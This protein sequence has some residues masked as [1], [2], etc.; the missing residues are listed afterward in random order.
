[1]RI[2]SRCSARAVWKPLEWGRDP[3][4]RVD[5]DGAARHGRVPV[6][7]QVGPGPVQHHRRLERG[8]RDLGRERADAGGGDAG[9]VRHR[10]GR[11]VRAEILPG[12]VLQDAAVGDAARLV[13]RGEIGLHPLAVPGRGRAGAA[14]DD[15]RPAVVVLQERA[16]ARRGGVGVDEAGRVGEAGEVVRVD[17]PRLEQAVHEAE[18]QEPVGAGRDAEPVVGHRVVAGADRV[19]RDDLR[20]PRL[21]LADADLERVAV[22]VL[23]HPE[24]EE[25]LR[26]LPVGRAELPEGAA[27][28]GDPGGGH[29]D[30]A[31]AAMRGVVGRAKRLRPPRGEGLRLVAPGEEGEAARLGRAD[32]GEPF[33]RQ[34]QRLVPCDLAEPARPARPVAQQ[35]RAEA[36]GRGRLHDPGR[37][38]G[39]KHA[40][41]H[42]MVA[43]ALDIGE[44]AVLEVDVD[45][46]AAGAHV[47]GGLAHLVRDARRRVEAVVCARHVWP[48]PPAPLAAAVRPGRIP[49][50]E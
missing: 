50:R 18:D 1:M 37:A 7:A 13:R 44:A 27:D 41:V 47:A 49:W 4:H 39:A 16:A 45:A 9:A 14:V 23:G 15:Q 40:P 24:E 30:R 36:G 48:V 20:A 12:D 8:A 2:C 28:G 10:L 43:V 31:E 3:A 25:Q 11:V 29:V 5:R 38:L 17:P 42:R 26:A 6:P 21:Q 34:R 32:R 33:R 22:V 19:D 46:A 35:G